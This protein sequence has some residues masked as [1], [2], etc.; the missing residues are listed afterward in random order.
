MLFWV[1][2]FAIIFIAIIR[3]AL[4]QMAPDNHGQILFV[5]LDTDLKFI[6]FAS[7]LLLPSSTPITCTNLLRLFPGGNKSSYEPCQWKSHKNDAGSLHS[8]ALRGTIILLYANSDTTLQGWTPSKTPNELWEKY[9]SQQQ[10]INRVKHY[11]DN[12]MDWPWIFDPEKAN[13]QMQ[14]PEQASSRQCLPC[15]CPPGLDL[16]HLIW[17]P[18][19]TKSDLWM[20]TTNP[21]V[22]LGMATKQT[23][24][25]STA[26]S[27]NMIKYK[28][29]FIQVSKFRA[30]LDRER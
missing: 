1:T 19:H 26:L 5:Y 8:C 6:H 21:R 13:K 10:K 23:K 25:N 17:F 14:A 3:D 7:P 11:I 27:R 2:L 28:K 15:M 30:V 29:P 20:Q 16:W 4:R 12:Q 24:Q 22:P 18:S 9:P